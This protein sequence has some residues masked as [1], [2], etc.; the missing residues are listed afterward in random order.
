MP[1]ESQSQWYTLKSDASGPSAINWCYETIDA[2]TVTIGMKTAAVAT[3]EPSPSPIKCNLVRTAANPDSLQYCSLRRVKCKC[4]WVG[5]NHEGDMLCW[6]KSITTN[7][8][9]D[10]KALLMPNRVID[11]TA[12]AGTDGLTCSWAR[13]PGVAEPTVEL[14]ETTRQTRTQ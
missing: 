5:I 6:N 11:A 12:C 9:N 8:R 13:V 4:K 1:M 14:M 7:R 10:N 3:Q 2:R